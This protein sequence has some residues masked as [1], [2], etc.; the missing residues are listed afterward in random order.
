MSQRSILIIEDDTG[1]QAVSKFSLEMD[2]HWQV[3]LARCGTEGLFKAKSMNPDVI[4]LDLVMPDMDGVEILE[5]LQSDNIV[6]NIPIILF[7]AK[8]IDWKIVKNEK[9]NVIGIINKPFDSL[10]L[11]AEISKLLE[12]RRYLAVGS[13]TK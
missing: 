11:S 8:L 9:S 6:S 13:V 3:A 12:R 2:G 7:T 5:Q 1:I 4:L 10:T